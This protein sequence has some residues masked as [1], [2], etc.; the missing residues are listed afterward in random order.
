VKTEHLTKAYESAETV[1]DELR[2]AQQENP[3][4]VDLIFSLVLDALKLHAKI[5]VTLKAASQTNAAKM[6]GT[7]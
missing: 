2:A 5:S 6:K 1:L 7:K 4:D 3:S